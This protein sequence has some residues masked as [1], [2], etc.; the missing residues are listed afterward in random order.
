MNDA[1]RV[2]LRERVRDLHRDIERFAKFE[3]FAID[4]P[5]RVSPSMYCM[6]MKLRESSS[7]TS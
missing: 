3:R 1:A 5:G 4:P 7:P 2:S 6:T